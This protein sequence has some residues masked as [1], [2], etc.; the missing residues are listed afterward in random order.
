MRAFQ[1][2]LLGQRGGEM[3]D[4]EIA[5]FYNAQIEIP[6]LIRME[7]YRIVQAA[8]NAPALT[9]A[10][11]AWRA[12]WSCRKEFAAAPRGDF[13]AT[14]VGNVEFKL[15]KATKAPA[16]VKER[17]AALRDLLTKRDK[18]G[19]QL[20]NAP[21]RYVGALLL[22][23]LLNRQGRSQEAESVLSR[24]FVAARERYSKEEQDPLWSSTSGK[25]IPRSARPQLL[26]NARTEIEQ[27]ISARLSLL[28][29]EREYL[30]EALLFV[31]EALLAGAIQGRDQALFYSYLIGEFHRRH[32]NLPLAAVWFKEVS[33]LADPESSYAQAAQLQ[34]EVVVEQAADNVNLLSAIGHDGE[35]IEK[36]REICK[37]KVD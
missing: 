22:A 18:A 17:I 4:D 12:A 25:G 21:E 27:E 36:L 5:T 37:T 26:E 30:Y 6:D 23:G 28:A 29:S 20:L 1:M 8:K 24:T 3:K 10:E 7:H 32:G 19:Y 33:N 9:R 2:R 15:E 11:A 14:R 16:G 13:L 34:Y 31:E 35:L